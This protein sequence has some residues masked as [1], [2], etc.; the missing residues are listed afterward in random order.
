MSSKKVIIFGTNDLAELALYYLAYDSPY[1]VWGVTKHERFIEDDE[2]FYSREVV[3][4]EELE[5]HYPPN[6]FCLFA[7]VTNNK[8]RKEI[9][10]EGIKKGYSFISY[11]SS[12]CT[13]F[14][15]SIGD[16]CFILEDNTLQPFTTIGN[17]VILWS[18]NHIGHHSTIEDNVFFTSHVVMSGHCHIKQGSFLGVNSTIRDGITIGENSII[19]MGSVVTKNVP[20]NQTWIGS[21]AKRLEYK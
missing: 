6:R 20:D 15:N 13:N 12:H 5:K 14:C 21:P 17:N 18:G 16:N 8:L 9:Y 11:I 3:P 7:P 19:G 4:F 2:M 1:E 10:E